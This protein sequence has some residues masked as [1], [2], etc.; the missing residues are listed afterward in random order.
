MWLGR[1][2]AFKK[3]RPHPGANINNIYDHINPY[4]RKQSKYIIIHIATNDALI[5]DKTSDIIFEQMLQLKRYVESNVPGIEVT[6]S[7]PVIRS[8]NGLANL[9]IIHLR[10]LEGFA[11]VS[12]RVDLKSHFTSTREIEF[13]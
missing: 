3:V 2:T 5:K 9:K 4:L 7:C 13:L 12:A 1:K 10:T 11:Y 6:I 8:D